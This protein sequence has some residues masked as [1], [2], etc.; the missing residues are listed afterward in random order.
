[1]ALKASRR[2]AIAPF[3]VMDVMRAADRR[4]RQARGADERTV[5]MEIGQPG[6]GAP[7][8][9]RDAAVAALQSDRLG[10]TDAFGVPELRRAIVEHYRAHYG[11]EV[12]FERVVVTTGSSGAFILAFLAAFDVGDRVAMVEPGYPAYRNILAALGV[13]VVGIPTDA[14]NRFSPTPELLDASGHLDG[15]IIASPANPTGTM[16]TR[17]TLHWIAAWCRKRG[18]RLVSDEI[19]H[20]IVFGEAAATMADLAPDALIINSFSKYFAMT[21]WRLGWMIVPEDLLRPVEVLAQNLFISP[22]TLPQRAAIAAFACR[23]EM[24]AQVQRYRANRDVLLD[25]LPAAGFRDFAPADGAFYLYCDV[26]ALTDDS[27]A[28]CRDMLEQAGVSATPGTDFDPRRGR[29]YVRFSFAGSES[30]IAEATRR[31]RRWRG[32]NS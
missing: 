10:Y 14:Q 31:L 15:L 4:D 7:Q 20:G 29:R 22:P 1:M 27:A 3:I 28:L 8:R 11:V 16:L 9:V 2:G 19:Y 6:V 12:P 32:V 18:V 24:D 21:G 23:A 5:H 17:D 26:S 30:D 13:E 25:Q